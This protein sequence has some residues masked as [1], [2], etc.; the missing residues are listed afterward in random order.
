MRAGREIIVVLRFTPLKLVH[1]VSDCN[2]YLP[3]ASV[4]AR[5]LYV[6]TIGV[7]LSIVVA[8]EFQRQG[9]SST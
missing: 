4:A 8:V 6:C 3:A 7:R 1:E 2:G 5:I 9:K